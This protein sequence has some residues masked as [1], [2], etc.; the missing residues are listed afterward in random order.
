MSRVLRTGLTGLP[1]TSNGHRLPS[2]LNDPKVTM[3]P[4]LNL[5]TAPARRRCFLSLPTDCC[6]CHPHPGFHHLAVGY[7]SSENPETNP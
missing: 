4:P 5:I 7:L 3:P 2:L 1:L 6:R